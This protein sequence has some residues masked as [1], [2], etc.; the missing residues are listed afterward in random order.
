MSDEEV[1]FIGDINNPKVQPRV[2]SG[3]ILVCE[4]L[5]DILDITH[6][7]HTPRVSRKDIAEKI[8]K[9]HEMYRVR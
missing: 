1:E 8:A 5:A 9:L 2:Y 4:I 6:P 3:K 7:N